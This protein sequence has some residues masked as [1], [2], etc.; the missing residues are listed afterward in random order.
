[1]AD[2]VQGRIQI[3]IVFKRPRLPKNKQYGGRI[4]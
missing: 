2:A 3:E 1:M 4:M